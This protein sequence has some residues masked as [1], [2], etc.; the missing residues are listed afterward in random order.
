MKHPLSLFR[1]CPRC[2]SPHF[3]TNDERSGICTDCGFVYYVNASTAV[4]AIIVNENK[5]MLLCIRAFDP[6]KGSL[7]LPGGFVDFGET[8]EESLIRE[9]KEEIGAEV[10]KL[11]YFCSFPNLYE[12]SGLD[13]HTL[14]IF[15]ICK[16]C[17]HSLLRPGDDVADFFF[18]PLDKINTEEIKLKSLRNAVEKY[19]LEKV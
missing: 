2:G 18:I 12:Y 6:Y 9:I 5:E 14:D 11:S 15:Y 7:G 1:Y 13:I 19:I 16:L 3:V 17:D 10:E 4:G 8:A